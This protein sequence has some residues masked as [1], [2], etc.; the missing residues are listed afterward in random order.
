MTIKQYYLE[1]KRTPHRMIRTTLKYRVNDI[2]IHSGLENSFVHV[3]IGG[4]E[5]F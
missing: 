4:A 1:L 3:R 5:G 2:N